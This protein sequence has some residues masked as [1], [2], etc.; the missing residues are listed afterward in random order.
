[1]R[2]L[3][4]SID[5]SQEI[6]V[7]PWPIDQNSISDNNLEAVCYLEEQ[8][9]ESEVIT[10]PLTISKAAPHGVQVIAVPESPSAAE[11]GNQGTALVARKLTSFPSHYSSAPSGRP[12]SC[13]TA[14][15]RCAPRK[16]INDNKGRRILDI[17]VF[18][19][20]PYTRQ[21]FF[22]M[23]A[24]AKSPAYVVIIAQDT[25]LHYY[26]QKLTSRWKAG[27]KYS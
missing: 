8:K 27:S 3:W 15:F 25:G 9:M 16:T 12:S 26:I 11:Q 1:V 19:R 18:E 7:N 6:G 2:N 10:K 21:A 24:D 22:P 14:Y 23:G 5:Q 4:I 17:R 13:N 20:H